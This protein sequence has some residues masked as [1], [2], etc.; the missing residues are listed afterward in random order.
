MLLRDI[1]W[2][3]SVPLAVT[4]AMVFLCT[5]NFFPHQLYYWALYL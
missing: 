3:A 4:P 5:E 2:T 1:G